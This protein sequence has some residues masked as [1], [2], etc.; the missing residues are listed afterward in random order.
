MQN[1]LTGHSATNLLQLIRKRE[2][3]PVEVVN[4]YLQ[5]IEKFNP[6]LNAIV[7]IAP[8]VIS[9]AKEAEAALT[10]GL[11]CGKLAGLPF[12]IKDTIETA[13]LRSTSGSLRRAY[14][15]PERDAPAVARLRAAGAII[16]GKTNTAEMAMDYTSD[17]PVFGRTNNPYDIT[18]SPGGS[19]GG[20]AAAIAARLSPAGLGSDLAGSVRIPSHFCGVA[21]MK[22]STVRVPGAGQFPPSTGPYSLGSVIGPMARSVN[23]LQLLLDVLANDSAPVESPGASELRGK[24]V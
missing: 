14:C 15:V 1:E 23:D 21:G 12:T 6:R 4:A 10:R 16:L 13:G 8:D 20:E 9:R 5:R 24:H 2:I 3:S 22:P 7:T 19:S 11:D 17:N 18:R